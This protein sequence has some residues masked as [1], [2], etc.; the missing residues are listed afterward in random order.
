MNRNLNDSHPAWDQLQVY[1]SFDGPSGVII[2]DDSGHDQHGVVIGN[3]QRNDYAAD[4]L[5]RN[6]S[7]DSI[8]PVL[9]FFNGIATIENVDVIETLPVEIP[10][11]S[12]TTYEIQNYAPVIVDAAAVWTQAYTYLLD[13]DGNLIDSTSVVLDQTISNDTLSYFQAPFEIINRFE[14]NRF[15]TMYGIGLDLGDNGWTWVTDVTDFAPLLRDSVELEAGNWQELLDLKFV[16]IEGTPAQ[17]VLRVERVWDGNYALNT[18]DQQVVAKEITKEEG[19]VAWKLLTTNTGHGFG[20]DNN[21]CGE[22]CNNMQSVKV[23]GSTIANWDILQECATNPL[24]PQGGTWVY[25]RAGWC[26]GMNSTTKEFDLT[27]AAGDGATFDVDYDITQDPYGNYVFF[28]TLI[29]YGPKNHLHDPEIDQILAPSAQLIHSR[30]NPICDN[31]RFVLRNK[32]AMPLTDLN[33][34]YGFEGGE[35]QS[36]HWT[37]NLQF[38]ESEEV[39]LTSND[40]LMWMGDDEEVLTFYVTLTLSSDGVDENGS[41]NHAE[42]VFLRPPTYQ[43]TNL[44][45]NRLIIQLKTNAS[46]LESSY[47]LYDRMGN[48]VF[49][50]S[51]FAAPNTTYR[52][53]LEI[54]AGCYMFH[55]RDAGDDGLSFFAND[56]GNGNCKLDRVSGLDF[57]NFE[58]NFGKEIIHYFNW[59]TDLVAVDEKERSDFDVRLYPNP[60]QSHALIK[61]QGMGRAITVCIVDLAGKVVFS[62]T[63]QR[64][65]E[66]EEVRIETALLSEGWYTVIVS[67][68]EHSVQV[69]MIHTR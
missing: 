31:P 51:G 12:W 28:G 16:F 52:D 49:E 39:E 2:Q 8:R 54:N 64:R 13:A 43:Y 20:F 7:V 41:N 18:F 65:F 45:D 62:E 57:I 40:A 10:P 33:I 61:A 60:N 35:P 22:F 30:W 42:S 25:D 29:G 5:W 59:N 17:D 21:N 6:A 32:G 9:R 36:F 23:N 4:Q 34:V 48:V 26:P 69:P 15:I 11:T 24:Y 37:G 66:G 46:N 56:D 53:T 47:T 14:L 67:D 55:L 50:R 68:E 44:D 27:E 19:E 1:Y 38:M 58:N 3:P 63:F